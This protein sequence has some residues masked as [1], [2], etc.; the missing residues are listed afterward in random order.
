M[1]V[2]LNETNPVLEAGIVHQIMLLLLF[3]VDVKLRTYQTFINTVK[4]WGLVKSGR[5]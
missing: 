1:Y 5:C 3:T 4:L 2:R